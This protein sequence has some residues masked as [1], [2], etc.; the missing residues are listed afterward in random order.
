MFSLFNVAEMHANLKEIEPAAAHAREC[1][2]LIESA[3]LRGIELAAGLTEALQK[4]EDKI[5][6]MRRTD[7]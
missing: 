4:L 2:E 7:L 3:R 5:V 6:Q 1:G